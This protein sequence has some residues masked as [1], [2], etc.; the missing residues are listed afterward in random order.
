LLGLLFVAGSLVLA[1]IFGQLVFGDPRVILQ[2]TIY[3]PN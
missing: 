3:G 2:P 1:A